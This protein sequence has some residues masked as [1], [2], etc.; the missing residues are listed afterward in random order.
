MRLHFAKRP[1]QTTG[2]AKEDETVL[3]YAE[4][5]DTVRLPPELG[6]QEVRVLRA[7]MRVCPGR[8]G[9]EVKCYALKGGVHVAECGA[10]GFL[11]FRPKGG[12]R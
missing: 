4:V 9:A 12:A 2:V 5:P 3:I 6:G 1:G 7:F 10:E 11:W 8:C